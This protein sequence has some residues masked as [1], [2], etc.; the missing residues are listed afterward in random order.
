MADDEE[1]ILPKEE[2][3]ALA[4]QGKDE[5]NKWA[6]ENSGVAV[7][8]WGHDFTKEE[9]SFAGFKFPG[10]VGF[11]GATILNGDFRDTNFCGKMN[12]IESVIFN[13]NAKFAKAK[14]CGITHFDH[15]IFNGNVSFEGT[16]FCGHSIEFYKTKFMNLNSFRSAIF[17]TRTINFTEAEF[18]NSVDFSGGIFK[19]ECECIDFCG[20]RFDK[21]VNFSE[22][23]FDV[24]RLTF[25]EAIFNNATFRSAKINSEEIN[26]SRAKFNHINTDFDNA[27]FCGGDVNF[28]GT[29]FKAGVTAFRKAKFN[30]GDALFKRAK[31]NGGSALFHNVDFS[32]GNADL[33]D[34]EFSGGNANFSGAQFSKEAAFMD[35]NFEYESSFAGAKFGGPVNL[36]G[37]RFEVVPDFRRST[38]SAHFTLHKMKVAYAI[39]SKKVWRVFKRA[40]TDTD[41]DKFRRLKE[42]AVQAR[43]HER[44]QDF[45]AK[46]LKAKRFYEGFSATPAYDT[47]WARKFI[48]KKMKALFRLLLNLRSLLVIISLL[49]SYLYEWTSDFGRSLWWPTYWL[50]MTWLY[51]GVGYWLSTLRF[52][53]ALGKFYLLPPHTLTEGL[54]LSLTTVVPFFALSRENFKSVRET[55]FGDNTGIWIDFAMVFEGV[56]AIIFIFLIG[57]ALRNRFR[58]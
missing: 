35:T 44:E 46:E 34:A 6:A 49:P 18:S 52:S 10:S 8:F 15:T 50:F 16:E 30:G 43:D 5:W 38:M 19:S 1:K 42:L 56:L 20:T 24:K 25:I 21:R 27:E 57:L 54:K 41:A 3:L 39:Q 58:I 11:R 32:G 9:I 45:F 22:I 28:E 55:L 29:E 26:F 23:E 13:G 47:N 36:E 4:R 37:S 17:S 31:F 51:F 7:E 53:E 48:V 2:A 12:F 33:S 14:F 40:A